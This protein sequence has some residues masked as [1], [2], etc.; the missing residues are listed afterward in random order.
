MKD[1]T[2]LRVLKVN[3]VH[4]NVHDTARRLLLIYI[5]KW[6]WYIAQDANSASNIPPW[7]AHDKLL[8]A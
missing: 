2:N 5:F 4:F 1:H 8:L 7:I 6:Q 3:N